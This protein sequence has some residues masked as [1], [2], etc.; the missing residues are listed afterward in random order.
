MARVKVFDWDR[1]NPLARVKY[2]DPYDGGKLKNEPKKAVSL[3][4]TY[5]MLGE[6]RPI[7]DI[8]YR[9]YVS[10]DRKGQAGADDTK[11]IISQYSLNRYCM[12][13]QWMARLSRYDELEREQYARER[14]AAARADR[15]VRIKTLEAFRSRAITAMA[16][17]DPASAN[18]AEVTAAL[19]LVTGELRTEHDLGETLN[20]N[21][22]RGEAV[23]TGKHNAG[24]DGLTDAEVE[25]AIANIEAAQAATVAS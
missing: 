5:A 19:R 4:H 20:K 16:L 25:D 10:A 23:T 24:F 7:K 14:R 8:F 2:P 17:L 13:F 12:D 3:L 1:D 21:T 9:D 22:A 18:W 11:A 15:A 6:A